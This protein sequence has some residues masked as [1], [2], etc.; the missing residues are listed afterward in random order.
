MIGLFVTT[1]SGLFCIILEYSYS[2]HQILASLGVAIVVIV[3][4]AGSNV[5]MKPFV[6]MCPDEPG[7]SWSASNLLLMTILLSGTSDLRTRNKSYR[8][9]LT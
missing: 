9:M 8:L 1:S 6:C 7:C 3:F 4:R 2:E 5:E